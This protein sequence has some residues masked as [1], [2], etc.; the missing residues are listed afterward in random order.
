MSGRNVDGVAAIRGDYALSVEE[1]DMPSPPGWEWTRLLDIARLESGHTP[2]RGHPEWWGGE[3]PWVGI[4]DAREHHGA[5]IHQTQENTNADGLANSA[6]RLLP[7]GT[8]CL[9]R[10]ASIGYSLI[11]GRPMATSQ[12]FVNWVCPEGLV[13]E[14]LQKLFLAEKEA[15]LRFGKGS[16]HKTIY[17]PE[18]KEFRVCVPPA[19]EQRRIVEKIDAL[20]AHSKKAKESLDRIPA[21]LEKLKKSILAAAFRGDLTKDWREAHPDVEP[22]D[23]LLE[24]IRAE[25]RRRWEE[26][27]LAKMRSKGKE[28]SNDRWKAKYE[29]PEMASAKWLPQL[30]PSWTW[31]SLADLTDSVRT[32]R[33]GILK[34]GPDIP[35]GVPYVKVKHI[36]GGRILTDELL[37][38]TRAMHEEFIGAELAAGDILISI[39][40]TW[41]R[42]APVPPELAGANITQDSARLAPLPGIAASYLIHALGH[43]AVVRFLDSVAKGMAVRGVNIGDLRQTPVPLPPEPEQ[44]ALVEM[45]DEAVS[46]IQAMVM[47]QSRAYAALDKLGQSVLA[48]AFRGQLVPQDPRDEPASV[49]LDRIRAEREARATDNT[50]AR[51]RRTP[52][53][54]TKRTGTVNGPVQLRESFLEMPKA[55]QA[56][57]VADVLLGQGVLARQ[58]AIRVAAESFRDLGLAEFKHLRSGSRLQ[59]A[60]DR[61]I[62]AGVKFGFLDRPGRGQIR[63]V[64]RADGGSPLHDPREPS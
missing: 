24:R 40:G 22:A 27:E 50:N 54:R 46:K 4:R 11:L 14:W 47:G 42:L 56:R 15:L 7:A 30:P 13:P 12:D 35:G 21:L 8:V 23:K 3:V 49:L 17:F 45:V 10:T 25:R 5:V 64:E 61:A 44:I 9:S 53:S 63:T 26:A 2:S 33:Y 19:N 43:P 39:R 55:D 60:I 51:V 41:G 62:N 18:V 1:T 58:L 37:R 52:R 16:V 6:A 28:P 20:F 48:K 57:A 38:T 32:I 31:A 36:K 59:T 34:P 29:E